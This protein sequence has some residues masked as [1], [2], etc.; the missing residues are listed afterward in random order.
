MKKR[1]VSEEGSESELERST[2]VKGCHVC[3]PSNYGITLQQKTIPLLGSSQPCSRTHLQSLAIILIHSQLCIARFSSLNSLAR[4]I[5]LFWSGAL[6]LH[7]IWH[8]LAHMKGDILCVSN[9]Q[10]NGSCHQAPGFLHTSR[11][12]DLAL[13]SLETIW[14]MPSSTLAHIKNGGVINNQI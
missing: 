14:S 2:Q 13:L 11:V 9:H 8:P 7:S 4:G 12:Y 1:E 3:I 10:A 5:L 6:L